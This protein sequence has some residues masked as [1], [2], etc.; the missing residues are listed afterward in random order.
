MAVRNRGGNFL[1]L[2]QKDGG[3]LRE[4]G[5]EGGSNPGGNY[6]CNSI[7]FA[8]VHIWLTVIRLVVTGVAPRVWNTEQVS[9]L[10]FFGIMICPNSL[11]LIGSVA[12]RDLLSMITLFIQYL[13]VSEWTQHSWAPVFLHHMNVD[14]RPTLKICLIHCSFTIQVLKVRK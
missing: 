11:C 12:C 13:S 5:W 10:R 2:L 4:R 14:G 9:F 8:Q 6:E 7:V 1:N 3:S